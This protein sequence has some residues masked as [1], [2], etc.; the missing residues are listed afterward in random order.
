MLQQVGDGLHQDGNAFLGVSDQMVAAM[1]KQSTDLPGNVVMVNV[2]NLIAFIGAKR[3]QFA[4]CANASLG[5]KEPPVLDHVN[6]VLGLQISFAFEHLPVRQPVRLPFLPLSPSLNL[7]RPRN[8]AFIKWFLSTP[9]LMGFDLSGVE[10]IATVFARTE[11]PSTRTFDKPP[12]QFPF[13]I[14]DFL[15]PLIPMGCVATLAAIVNAKWL[16]AGMRKFRSSLDCLTNGANMLI[17]HNGR[18]VRALSHEM[19]RQ[20]AKPYGLIAK[21]TSYESTRFHSSPFDILASRINRLTAPESVT[22]HA[23]ASLSSLLRIASSTLTTKLASFGSFVFMQCKYTTDALALQIQ[24][25]RMF[26]A[27]NC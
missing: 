3:R 1:A 21:A 10:R 4:N 18:L 19:T 22:D 26:S 12:C 11:Y 23:S 16:Q 13:S 5:L 8:L 27:V 24:S 2:K 9:S 17:C 20:H 7:Q 6:S 14:F 25:R 15:R